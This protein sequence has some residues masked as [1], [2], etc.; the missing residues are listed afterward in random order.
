VTSP[1]TL[2]LEGVSFDFG[3]TLVRVDRPGLRSVIEQTADELLAAGTIVEIAP[4]LAA[5]VEERDRQFREDVPNLREVD[6]AQRVIRVLARMRGERPPAGEEAWDDIAAAALV[7]AA[8]VEAA[9]E[10]YSAAFIETIEA[11][12]G[13]GEI[14]ARLA[15]RGF[16]LAILSN[17][18]LAATIDRFVDA[19]GWRPYLGA[20]V[21][22]QRVGSIKPDPE[23]FRQAAA[24][25]RAPPDRLL[26]VGD[27]WAAD[28][29]GASEAGWHVAYVRNRQLDT[30]LPTSAPDHRVVAD[31]IVDR[32]EEIDPR[33]ERWTP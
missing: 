13:S 29:V 14:L 26:H 33:I 11:L 2:R 22:S 9:I 32:L 31:L 19:H 30:P 15:A 27:D 25:L 28:V 7:Q 6:M 4:F 1:A 18:P 5:W 12:P 23:I 21:V 16:R 8:E 3:N 10:I 24:A 17:W 20:L